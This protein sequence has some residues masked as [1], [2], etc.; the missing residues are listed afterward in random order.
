MKLKHEFGGQ[1]DLARRTIPDWTQLEEQQMHF[2]GQ[3]RQVEAPVQLLACE[4]KDEYAW[5]ESVSA[6][7]KRR[8]DILRGSALNDKMDM[9]KAISMAAALFE[10]ADAE[11]AKAQEA[12]LKSEGAQRWKGPRTPYSKCVMDTVVR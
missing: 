11:A 12:M 7:E 5:G 4:W 9:E 8:S 2:Y 1:A 10:T 3:G 6:F